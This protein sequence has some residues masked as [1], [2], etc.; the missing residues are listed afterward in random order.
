[1][2]KIIVIFFLFSKFIFAQ[3]NFKLVKAVEIESDFFVSDNQSNLYVAKGNELT[4][5][6]KT[7]KQLYKYSNKNLGI[8]DFVD[9]SNQLKTLLFYKNFSQAVFLDNT[10]S[11]SGTPLSFDQIGFQ[12]IQLACTSHNNCL[13]I[14]DQQTFSIVRLNPKNEEMQRTGNLNNLLNIELQ[15]NFLLEHDNK[16]YINNPNTGIL[17]FDIY[18][19]YYKTI[20]LKNLQSFQ[21]IS[22]WVYY[23]S[24]QQ[25]KAYNTKTT[26]EKEFI[27]PQPDF[28]SFS[29][30]M[31]N[32]FLKN[33]NKISI[34]AE[35]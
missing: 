20:P 2:K 30:Q 9:V 14:Y 13:W 5:F 8:I 10:L 31:G 15:P 3:S 21:P 18:G 16:V 26:E 23:Q 12:Q 33:K 6:D 34:Y 11:M 7:G 17:I 28:D 27:L 1:M 35:Q 4:K 29:L 24:E 19:T 22:E 25:I 32:L